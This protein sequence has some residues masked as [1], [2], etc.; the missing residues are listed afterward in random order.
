M[1][2]VTGQY[3]LVSFHPLP[4]CRVQATRHKRKWQLSHASRGRPSHSR[5][6]PSR[7]RDSPD[8]S[9]ATIGAPRCDGCADGKKH[10]TKS[11]FVKFFGTISLKVVKKQSS[12]RCVVKKGNNQNTNQPTCLVPTPFALLLLGLRVS[13]ATPQ[14]HYDGGARASCSSPSIHSLPFSLLPV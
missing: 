10:N 3:L 2:Q 13:P 14:P 12:L 5:E 4:P 1:R 6:T 11:V 9:I 8:V 7:A